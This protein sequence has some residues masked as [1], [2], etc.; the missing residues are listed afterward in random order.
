M[1][2]F[3]M[4]A[5]FVL[6]IGLLG[7]FAAMRGEEKELGQEGSGELFPHGADDSW[8]HDITK[9]RDGFD[10]SDSS[11]SSDFP[12]SGPFIINPA[13]G[14]PMVDGSH[15]DVAGN[16]YGFDLS[17]DF[18]ASRYVDH[19]SSGDNG[20]TSSAFGGCESSEW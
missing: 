17:H 1:E 4:V 13:N 12:Q 9:P 11:Q 2:L 15:I 8:N 16:P 18:T 5:A 7:S 19:F 20:C 6:L 10:D 3:L 14:L